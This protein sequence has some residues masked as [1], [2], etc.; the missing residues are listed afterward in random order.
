MTA[1]PR[2]P[3][4]IDLLTLSAAFLTGLLG[5]AHC[6]AMCGGIAVS[7]AGRTPNH[8]AL[9]HAALL[10]A[11]RITSYALAGALVGGLG[12]G[13]LRYL[14]IPALSVVFRVAMGAVMILIALRLW[15]QKS[16]FSLLSKPGQWV[17]AT[18]R[19]LRDR[20]P[21]AGW[22]RTVSLGLLWGWLPCGLSSTVL[23]AAW[24]E[25]S[26]IHG[27]LLMLSFGL[28]TFSAMTALSWSGAQLFAR[29]Q[30]PATRRTLALFIGAAGAL[31]LAAPWL[32]H[33]PL[34]HASL[35]ALGCRSLL[36]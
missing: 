28:G 6:A 7:L 11:A 33:L 8:H 19:P 17:W 26:A 12:G 16:R 36:P 32:V 15:G 14:P 3:M 21:A 9:Q 5:S 29:W 22:Q 25:G 30:H 31:T 27:S 23:L 13:M 2:A 20:I 4:P 1:T 10:N 24:L 35:T 34:V 18:L